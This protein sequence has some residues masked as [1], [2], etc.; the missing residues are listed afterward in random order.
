MPHALI[1]LLVGLAYALVFHTL[2]YIRREGYS[3]QFTLEVVVLTLVAVGLSVLRI[4]QVDPVLLVIVLYLVTMRVRLLVDLAN[5]V[6][7]SHRFELAGRIYGLAW[8]LLPGSFG[9]TVIAANQGAIM[10]WQEQLPEAIRVLEEALED[11][12]A[13]PKFAAAIHYNLG[14]AYRKQ[15]ESLQAVKH[16]HAAIDAL[17]NSIHAQRAQGLLRRG[18]DD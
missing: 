13:R 6:A 8:Q 7:R 12:A 10:V 15:G 17:P 1:L 4:A 2:Q 5:L 3:P 18:P 14:V 9:Q 11:S 16:L